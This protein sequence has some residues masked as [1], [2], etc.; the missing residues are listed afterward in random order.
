MT[1]LLHPYFLIFLCLLVNG[2]F[3]QL[4]G[5]LAGVAACGE[6]LHAMMLD[7]T[8]ALNSAARTP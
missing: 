1:D 4:I 7:R 6:G 2:R 5:R 3:H 8:K